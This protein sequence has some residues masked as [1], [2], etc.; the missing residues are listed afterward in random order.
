MNLSHSFL[1]EKSNMF[2]PML[3]TLKNVLCVWLNFQPSKSFKII[4]DMS[5]NG[6]DSNVRLSKVVNILLC[7]MQKLLA[8]RKLFNL[9]S[10][11]VASS[12]YKKFSK[13]FLQK[14][15][16]KIIFTLA[17]RKYD[18]PYFMLYFFLQM[19]IIHVQAN[20][21]HSTSV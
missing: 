12:R 9:N 8:M 21:F 10:M 20:Y 16:Q 1:T 5:M 7:L 13:S 17:I 4:F 14:S 11:L 3:S 15:L 19:R 18:S 2:F 6:V